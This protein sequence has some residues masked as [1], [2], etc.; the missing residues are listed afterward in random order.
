MASLWSLPILYVVEN[1]HIAQTTPSDSAVAGNISARFTA[2]NIPA[3]HLDT[4]DVMEI[5]REAGALVRKVRRERSPQAL[6]IDTARLGSHSKGDDT[7]S[8]EDIERLWS[9]SDPVN[10]CGMALQDQIRCDIIYTVMNRLEAAFN[11]AP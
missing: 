7:R 10:D 1:N 3:T 2:F 11:A 5:K 9:M 6:V 8:E 4:S